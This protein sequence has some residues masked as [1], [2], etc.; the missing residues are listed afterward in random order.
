M[1]AVPDAYY[2]FVMHYA[3]WFYVITTTMA[4]DPPADQKNILTSDGSKFSAGMKV[5][6]KDSAVASF[7]DENL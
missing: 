2:E 1:G 5:E 7:C 4:A 3:P 6:I